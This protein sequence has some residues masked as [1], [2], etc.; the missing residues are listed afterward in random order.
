MRRLTDL[1][2]M[3]HT[4]LS[5]VVPTLN[6]QTTF[7]DRLDQWRQLKTEGVEIIVV[8]GGSSDETFKLALQFSDTVISSPKGRAKQMNAGAAIATGEYLLFLHADTH[9]PVT[10]IKEL[11]RLRS[12]KN[13]WGRF[14][15]RLNNSRTIFRLIEFMMNER[16]RLTKI[17]TGDQAMFVQREAF[18]HVGCFP[19][20]PLMEDIELSK[21]LSRLNG[22]TPLNSPII[23]SSRY[24]ET[25]G[26]I[27]STL[28][29]WNL[30]LRYFLGQHPKELHALYY[31]QR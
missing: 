16:S 11:S 17:C 4:W 22:F 19:D 29:M 21:R 25:H 12:E 10:N 2:A 6:E 28:R 15:V 9:F 26:V 13:T 3:S 5:I 20:Q 18:N 1:I 7:Q 24:W 14:N 8:D 30:R 27:R 31:R 23:V